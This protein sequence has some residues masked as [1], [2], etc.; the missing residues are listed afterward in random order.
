MD[1]KIPGIVL[2]LALLSTGV[3]ADALHERDIYF[4][5]STFLWLYAD[6]R[7]ENSTLRTGFQGRSGYQAS[8]YFGVEIRYSDGGEGE[9]GDLVVRVERAFSALVTVSAAFGNGHRVGVYGGHTT[10]GLKTLSESGTG[11]TTEHGVSTGTFINL[12]LTRQTYVFADYGTWLWDRDFVA[13][14]F[15]LGVGARF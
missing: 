10:A 4:G 14:G 3:N 1:N 9:S 8:E 13:Q 11:E 5:A 15:N 6:D 2:L 12:A 7:L